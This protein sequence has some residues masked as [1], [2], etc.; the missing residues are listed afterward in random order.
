[1][2]TTAKR[3]G[4]PIHDVLVQYVFSDET[5]NELWLTDI[6]EHPTGEGKL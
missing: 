5:V 2:P 1:M 6:T 4:S 3:P